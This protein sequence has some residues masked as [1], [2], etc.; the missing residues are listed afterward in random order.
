M[1]PKLQTVDLSPLPLGEWV[2]WDPAEAERSP[3]LVDAVAR[4]QS[5]DCE[6][7]RKATRFL[8]EDAVT[9]DGSTKTYLLIVDGEIEGFFA[10]CNGSVRLHK[11][12][13]RA[14]LV[15]HRETLPAFIVAWIARRRGGSVGGEHLMLKAIAVARQQRGHVGCVVLALDPGDANVARLWREKY[16]FEPCEREAAGE[17]GLER[18]WLRID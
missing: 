10:C 18:L 9:N 6:T 16:G 5:M 1:M 12:Q 14:L 11:E 15:P 7:G 17:E 2:I 13:S 8:R 3:E 4:F